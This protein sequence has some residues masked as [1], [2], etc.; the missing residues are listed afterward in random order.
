MYKLAY[1]VG[2]M[3]MSLSILLAFHYQDEGIHLVPI[4]T[5]LLGVSCFVIGKFLY[6]KNH[7][8]SKF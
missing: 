1:I 3:L 6:R 7:A 8:E 5:F 2:L 4:I